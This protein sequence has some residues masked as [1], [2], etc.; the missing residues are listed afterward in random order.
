MLASADRLVRTGADPQQVVRNRRIQLSRRFIPPRD[1]VRASERLADPGSVVLLDGPRGGGRRT[2]AIMLLHRLGESDGRFEELSGER[3]EGSL[4]AAPGDRFFVDLSNT[5]EDKYFDAQRTVTAYRTAIETCDARMVVVV[6]AGLDYLLDPELATL[7]V[8]LGRPRGMSVFRQHLRVDGISPEPEQL[9]APEL[10]ELLERSPMRELARLA[11]MVRR[12]RDSGQ[13]G[14]DFTSWY[15][16][17]IAAVTNWTDRVASQVKQHRAAHQRALLLT[18]AMFN[19]ASAD[20]VFHGSRTL[21]ETLDHGEDET[22]RLAQADLGEQLTALDIRRDREGRIGFDHLAYDSAVRTHFWVNF[23]DL[24]AGLRTWVQRSAELPSLTADDRKELVARFAEQ[25]LG[26]GCPEHLW[27][28]A[29]AWTQPTASKTLHPEAAAV[30]EHGLNHERYAAKFRSQ[31][32]Q[33][34]TSSRLSADLVRVLTGVCQQVMAATHPDQAMVRLHHLAV[35]GGGEEHQVA[36]A[37]LIELAARSRRLYRRLV[38]RLQSRLHAQREHNLALLTELAEPASLPR[39]IPWPELS[40]AW[41]TVLAERPMADWAP[42]VH[43]WLSAVHENERWAPVLRVLMAATS[44]RRDLLDRLY[45]VTC[46]WAL[47]E[48][49]VVPYDRAARE[50]TAARLWQMIDLAQGADVVD[51]DA[52]GASDSGEN[53]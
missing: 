23:P 39:D 42:A 11:D 53:R 10:T 22:P 40:A 1:Y 5:A 31:I 2:A 12:A 7:V 33:W 43:R 35:R 17:A 45:V 13:Y 8:R 32:Y 51:D 26:V 9:T 24:R 52:P 36:R 34:V 25:S 49:Q 18:A 50:A 48:S 30:L 27:T 19:G 4:D 6:P 37:A 47:T 38:E 41:H 15:A 14:D 16:E 28:L 20:A 3:E 44:N 46:D 29:E 21:L